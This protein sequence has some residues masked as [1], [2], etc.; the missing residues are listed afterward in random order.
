MFIVSR[1]VVNVLCCLQVEFQDQS[2]LI[3]KHSEIHQLEHELPKRVRARLV[4]S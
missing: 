2:Q 1:V 4:S 3:L